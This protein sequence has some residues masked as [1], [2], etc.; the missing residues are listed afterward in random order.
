[1]TITKVN[2]ATRLDVNK[3]G[4]TYTTY[5]T[6]WTASQWADL[7]ATDDEELLEIA[8][9]PSNVDSWDVA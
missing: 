1:M 5:D 2:L 9:D 6:K 8:T 7:I 4:M 3:D